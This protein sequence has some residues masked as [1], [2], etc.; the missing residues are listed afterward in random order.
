MQIGFG[1]R[2]PAV[3][4]G[5]GDL[6]ALSEEFATW[7]ADIRL[8]IRAYAG[9]YALPPYLVSS[10]RCIV[11][12][13]QQVLVI[14]DAGGMVGVLPGG[15]LEPGEGWAAA[16]CREVHEETGVV[17]LPDSLQPLGFLHLE[18]V[19]DV[20]DEH[21]YPHPDFFQVVFVGR[22]TGA[23][24]DWVDTDDGYV[25]RSWLH[26]VE[27]YA[28]LALQAGDRALLAVALGLAY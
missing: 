16:A 11:F 6:P 8:R 14:E 24:T 22:A 28:D 25:E 5:L 13:E 20:A 18:H 1:S 15:R 12:V 2:D 21:R 3:A 10:V 4:V 27:T 23:P 17:L 9:I 26:P 19:N 7:G